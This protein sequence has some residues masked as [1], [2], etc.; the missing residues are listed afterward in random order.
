[1][2]DQAPPEGFARDLRG[3]DP[4][5]RCRWA[6]HQQIWFI[7]RKLPGERHPQWFAER[8]SPWGTSKRSLDLWEGWKEGYV[9]VLSV[10]PAL[11]HWRLVQEELVRCDAERAGGFAALNAELDAEEA[12]WQAAVDRERMNFC[13]AAARESHDRIQWMS[14]NRIATPHGAKD[15]PAGGTLWPEASTE[16]ARVTPPGVTDA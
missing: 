9:H 10:P 8:P 4:L 13:E 14:G 12:K 7:E 6:R 1:M 5:L 11:L 15:E 3:Y 16:P 2:T